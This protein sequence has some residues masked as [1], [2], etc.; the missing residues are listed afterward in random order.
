MCV[1][2]SLSLPLP[3][4]SPHQLTVSVS[5][6]LCLP[7]SLSPL[8]SFSLSSP[9]LSLLF[10][11]FLCLY[12]LK[13]SLP[14]CLC[15]YRILYLSISLHLSPS[16]PLFSLLSLSY[17]FFFLSILR[18]VHPWDLAPSFPQPLSLTRPQHPT[19]TNQICNLIQL[20]PAK[21]RRVTLLISRLL[22][23]GEEKIKIDFVLLLIRKIETLH[24]RSAEQ[25]V[26]VTDVG[27]LH[28][29][30]GWGWGV[31][32]VPKPASFL[33]CSSF[34]TM[35]LGLMTPSEAR[36]PGPGKGGSEV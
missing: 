36:R 17:F 12:L 4:S 32:N 31:E 14:L 13:P 18:P 33:S 19:P 23:G 25:H 11:L 5:H 16:L 9:F 34:H 30:T 28:S 8:V 15:L 29:C 27:S 21:R 26:V 35:T 22:E 20:H 2:F 24:L 3:L 1:S 6:P 10:C 7:L